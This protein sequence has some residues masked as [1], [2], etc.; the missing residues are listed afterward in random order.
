M[1]TER[2]DNASQRLLIG[3]KYARLLTVKA[4]EEM[5]EYAKRK[6]L[7]IGISGSEWVRQTLFPKGWEKE[8]VT[9]RK[10]QKWGNA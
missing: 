1:K 6:G 5:R 3:P 7:E 8:L 4:S 2:R 9:L 10:A